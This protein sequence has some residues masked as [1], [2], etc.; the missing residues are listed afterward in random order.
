[1][2]LSNRTFLVIGEGH[3]ALALILGLCE[4]QLSFEICSDDTTIVAFAKE[5]GI[6]IAENI[7]GWLKDGGRFVISS[8]YRK[9]ISDD[10]LSKGVFLNIHYAL[11]PKYRGMHS[12]VWAL[13]NGDRKIGITLHEMSSDLDAGPIL[14]QQKVPVRKMTSWDLMLY[15]DSFI[16]RNVAKILSSYLDGKLKSRKQNHARATYVAKRTMSDCEIDWEHWGI[17]E[18]K[19]HMQALVEPYPLPFFVH[20]GAKYE[21]IK[22]RFKKASYKEVL[23]RVVYVSGNEIFV[24]LRDGLAIIAELRGVDGERVVASSLISAPGIRLRLS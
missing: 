4:S 16:Q 14:W 20:N 3:G 15:C 7:E 13:L 10:L 5:K 6:R 12:I 22:I 18:F 9:R 1:M 21:I 17:Q 24:K 19:R 23:G 2:G 8:G 11:F